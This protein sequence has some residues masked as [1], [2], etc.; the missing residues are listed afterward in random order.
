MK[1]HP[2]FL[3]IILVTSSCNAPANTPSVTS[4]PLSLSTNTP[5]PPLPQPTPTNT[6]P[7]LSLDVTPL[8]WFAPLPPLAITAGR[9]F[10]GS[11]DFMQL[12]EPAAPWGR[13]QDI[14]RYSTYMGNESHTKPLTHNS[15]KWWKIY[16]N[17]VSRWQLNIIVL[18]KTK[19]VFIKGIDRDQSNYFKVKN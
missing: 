6:V 3:I 4:V 17:A 15:N 11:D 9:D 10:T 7:P 5:P 2:I 12:F 13:Q 1:I 16:S 8:A 18:V 19:R 14:F